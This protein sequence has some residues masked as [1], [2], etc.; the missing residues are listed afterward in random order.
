MAVEAGA[1]ELVKVVAL[2]GAAVVMVP[3]FRRLGLG[4]VLGYFAAGLAIGP[5][6]FGWFSD[7]QAILHTAELG[8]VMFLFV[9]GLEMRPSH[10][11]SLRN[12]IFGLGTLQI[13]VCGTVLT[14]VCMLL[15]FPLPVA[16]IG[17][18]GFL[19]PDL[20]SSAIA[21]VGTVVVHGAL[22]VNRRRQAAG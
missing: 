1:S 20:Q 10:L 19:Y 17:A 21:A 18:A 2:L 4:S 3:L 7:P 11:W 8:V 16:F 6:G 13:V 22:W 9:I 5:F 15:G 14:G 12:E